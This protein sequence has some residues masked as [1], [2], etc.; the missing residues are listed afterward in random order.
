MVNARPG[1]IRSDGAM[2]NVLTKYKAKQVANVQ[3]V[4]C[5]KGAWTCS[6]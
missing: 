4:L 3:P 5:G 1:E 6:G 2:V